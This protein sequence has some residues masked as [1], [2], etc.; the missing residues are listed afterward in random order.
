MEGDN[1]HEGYT[2]APPSPAALAKAC[3]DGREEEVRALLEREGG[4]ALVNEPWGP[5]G[6]T[7]LMWAARE[8]HMGVVKLLLGGT[9]GEPVHLDLK[10]CTPW[11]GLGDDHHER[12][13]RPLRCSHCL[14]WL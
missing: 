10:V 4:A 11:V 13:I 7:P 8:G 5:G 2:G 14:V 6:H 9:W 12:L 3:R 1:I